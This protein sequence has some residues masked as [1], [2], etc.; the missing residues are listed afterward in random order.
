[1][2]F[3]ICGGLEKEMELVGNMLE[4]KCEKEVQIRKASDRVVAVVLAFEWD[5]LR[6]ICGYALQRKD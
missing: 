6:L 3:S 2:D 5:V 1:M 4:E